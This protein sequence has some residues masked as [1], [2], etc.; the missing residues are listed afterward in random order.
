[1]VAY[2]REQ[3]GMKLEEIAKKA[4]LSGAE[5]WMFWKR[6]QLKL[7]QCFF[8]AIRSLLAPFTDFSVIPSSFL[9][10]NYKKKR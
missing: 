3:K 10:I 4:G 9:P 7:I 6:N 8:F 2:P 5:A 1:M